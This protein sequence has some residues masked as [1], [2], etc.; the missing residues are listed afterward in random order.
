M[1]SRLGALSACGAL[2]ASLLCISQGE[3]AIADQAAVGG[4]FVPVSYSR[5][6]DTKTGKGGSSLPFSSSETRSY[7]VLG[8]NGVPSTGVSAVLVDIAATSATSSDSWAK[9]YPKGAAIPVSSVLRFGSGSVPRS[10]TVVVQP[11]LDGSISVTNGPGNTDFNI[12]VQGYF[13]ATSTSSTTSTGGFVPVDAT[14]VLDT[15]N[16]IGASASLAAGAQLD[17]QVTGVGSIASTATSVFANVGVRNVTADGTL[18]IVPAGQPVSSAQPLVN[19]SAGGPDDSG[20]SIPLSSDGRIT[21]LNTGTTP[22]DLFVDVQGFFSGDASQGGGF[23]ATS[24]TRILDLTGNPLGARQ[25]MDVA[26]GGTNGM[27]TYGVGGAMLGIIV[28]GY[29][30]SGNVELFRTGADAPNA[31]DVAFNNAELG[32]PNTSTLVVQPGDLGKVTLINN[33][34]GPVNVKLTLQGWFSGGR[35]VATANE[36]LFRAAAADTGQT[37]DRVE[38]GIYE[39]PV[40]QAI[41]VGFMTNA[42]AGTVTQNQIDYLN[43]AGLLD[44][45]P[46]PAASTP[47]VVDT[48]VSDRVGVNVDAS[49]LADPSPDAQSTTGCSTSSTARWVDVW[50]TMKSWLGSTIYTWHHRVDYC[51]KDGNVTKFLDR[52]DYLTNAQAQIEMKQ[53]EVNQSGGVGTSS[54]WSHK[55]RHL[56]ACLLKYGCWA[57]YHPWSK[58]TVNGDG[59]Y[60]YT[61]EKK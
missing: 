59:T 4:D 14:R 40:N 1:F 21:I 44:Q 36:T 18:K 25:Q 45:V 2:I 51:T 57:N 47:V 33:S 41:T 7:G 56:Q 48:G 28:D 58:I 15:I 3:A 60:S 46:D 5:L 55:Q 53:L 8:T 38:Q 13:T 37:Q 11:G 17:V 34:D 30:A 31:A 29:T 6:V 50:F 22:V 35:A 12:D 10:N 27:P 39:G 20:V 19:F 52:Y 32:A 16:N 54:A 24:S 26:I 9:V 23:N 42:A 61:G 49:G 43:A